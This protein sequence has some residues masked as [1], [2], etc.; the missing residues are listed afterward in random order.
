MISVRLK[1]WFSQNIY[2]YVFTCGGIYNPTKFHQLSL[3]WSGG[4]K[5]R[6]RC[7]KTW[8]NKNTPFVLL[9]SNRIKQMKQPFKYISTYFQITEEN[10]YP[11]FL[12]L[13]HTLLLLRYEPLFSFLVRPIMCCLL[14]LNICLCLTWRQSF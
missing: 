2:E 13:Y 8:T 14:V 6:H 12:S 11:D 9:C 4:R 10:K 3:Y 7:L 1:D 5:T